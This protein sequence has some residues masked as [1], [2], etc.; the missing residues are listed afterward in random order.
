MI[1]L[2]IVISLLAI[3]LSLGF[4]FSSSSL[5][6]QQLVSDAEQLVAT[7]SLG[8]QLA[9]TENQPIEVRFYK[10]NPPDRSLSSSEFIAYQLWRIG[11]DGK[12]V[13]PVSP[14]GRLGDGIIFASDPKFS[15]LFE[16]NEKPGGI[17]GYQIAQYVAFQFLPEGGTNLPANPKA[18]DGKQ[19]FVTLGQ[20]DSF[21]KTPDD[22]ACVVIDQFT[23][24][25]RLIRP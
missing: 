14:P 24:T 15:S 21:T 16:L 19:W 13:D 4:T 25:S 11:S 22:F 3:L 2:L 17:G 1:E 9:T 7:L 20:I 6:G 8:Q 12:E 5:S 18:S 10:Y 23:G